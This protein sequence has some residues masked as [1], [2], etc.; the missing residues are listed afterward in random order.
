[1]LGEWF[2]TNKEIPADPLDET[3]FYYVSAIIF[4]DLSEHVDW[5]ARYF[6]EYSSAPRPLDLGYLLESEVN[7][8]S[9]AYTIQEALIAGA[10]TAGAP[11]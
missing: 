7:E 11:W 4:A 8:H 9:T 6:E 1:M 5:V 2:W 10:S 3:M